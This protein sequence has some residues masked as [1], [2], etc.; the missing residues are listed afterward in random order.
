M[1]PR[2]RRPLVILALLTALLPALRAQTF[3]PSNFERVFAEIPDA[4]NQDVLVGYNNIDG[5]NQHTFL[6][7]DLSSL[8]GL[9]IQSATL[10]LTSDGN[11]QGNLNGAAAVNIFR[12]ATPL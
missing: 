5:N 11:S 10:T 8:A 6:L 4:T 7:F 12:I 1:H 2:S 9:T 3:T